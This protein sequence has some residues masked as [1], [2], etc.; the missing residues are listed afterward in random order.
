M[1]GR[2]TPVTPFG[3]GFCDDRWVTNSGC[4]I[5]AVAEAIREVSETIIEARFETLAQCDIDEKSPGEPVTVLDREA[6]AALSERLTAIVGDAPVVGEESCSADPGRLRWLDAERAWLVDPLDG[7][8]NYLAGS[9]DFAVMVALLSA[10]RPVCSWV[11]QPATKRM[12]IAERGGGASCNGSPVRVVPAARPIGELTG[13]ALTRFMGP[14]VA[15]TVE[16]NRHKFA[17]VSAGRRCAGVEYPAVIHGHQD[18]ALFWRTLPWDHIPGVLLL[19]EAG[20]VARRPNATPY[21]PY[22]HSDVG[23]LIASDQAT[24]TLAHQLLD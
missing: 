23:L 15:A 11:W 19:E 12:Y 16:R 14:P 9:S 7:T 2:S 17:A 24:W 4:V 20:G 3:T 5:A 6:E 1:A 8:A 18:F 22:N 10:G 13:A 21:L